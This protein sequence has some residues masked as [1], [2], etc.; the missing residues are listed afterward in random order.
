MS[1]KDINKVIE[2]LVKE[3]KDSVL[4]Y[5]KL[6]KS[7]QK[8]QLVQTLKNFLALIQLC[9]VTVISSQEQTKE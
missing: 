7:F 8:H 5:E 2:Q 4:T 3:Y 9:N 6:L 1:V